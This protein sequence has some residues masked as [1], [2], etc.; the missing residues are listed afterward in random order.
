MSIIIPQ[1]QTEA[2]PPAVPDG[3]VEAILHILAAGGEVRPRRALLWAIRL[4]AR[5][6]LTERYRAELIAAQVGYVS[7]YDRMLLGRAAASLAADN[8]AA[9]TAALEALV[10][11]LPERATRSYYRE[12][13]LDAL[14]TPAGAR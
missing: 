4:G 12:A 11:A 5:R 13:L 3:M 1:I 7:D 9:K 8:A 14:T 2:P 6:W 10:P